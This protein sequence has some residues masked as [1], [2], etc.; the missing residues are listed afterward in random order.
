[1]SNEEETMYRK[2]RLG[3]G[4]RVFNLKRHILHNDGLL[5][6]KATGYEDDQTHWIGW[7]AVSPSDPEYGFWYWMARVQHV[8]ELVLVQERELSNWKAIYKAQA[9][10]SRLETVRLDPLLKQPRKKAPV[11]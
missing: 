7:M 8:P 10:L 11:K 2:S 9:N 5:T 6:I 4:H 3:G 1:M